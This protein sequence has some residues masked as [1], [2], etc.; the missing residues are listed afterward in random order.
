[1]NKRACL[2]VLAAGIAGSG[3]AH[4]RS[5]GP[6]K[7]VASLPMAVLADESRVSV[8]LTINGKPVRL[9]VDTGAGMSSLTTT[10]AAALGLRLRDSGTAHLLNADGHPLHRYYL[11]RDL[12]VGRLDARN[13]PFLQWPTDLPNVDGIIGPD[14]M[15]RYDVDMDFAADRLTYFSQDHCAGHI[16]HWPAQ[17]IAQIPITVTARVRDY[18]P[19]WVNPAAGSFDT[20]PLVSP[21]LGT[22]IRTRVMLDGRAFTANIDTGSEFST[23]NSDAARRYFD[24]RPDPSTGLADVAEPKRDPSPGPMDAT[25]ERVTVTGWRAEHRFHTLTIGGVTVMNPLFVLHAGPADADRVGGSRSPDITIGMN[26]LGKLHLYF[27][28]GERM[29]YVSAADRQAGH[30]RSGR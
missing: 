28:F 19:P 26:V 30:G 4:A 20:A 24:V 12:K 25:T 6:L 27:A 8:P 21:I 1:M 13:I 10:A 9:M 5:C 11:P 14:L 23:I 2:L 22:D 18:P 15:V 16:V 17:A 29:L 3:P 7:E